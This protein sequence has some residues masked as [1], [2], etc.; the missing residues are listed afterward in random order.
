MKMRQTR[1]KCFWASVYRK[2]EIGRLEEEVNTWL[3]R[4][5]HHCLV[6]EIKQSISQSNNFVE[7]TVWYEDERIK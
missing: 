7:I 3:T 1:V 4:A 5:D 2:E 6:K